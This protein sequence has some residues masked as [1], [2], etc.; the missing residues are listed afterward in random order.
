MN[1]RE[2][3]QFLHAYLDGELDVVN[4]LAVEQH[5][6]E[7]PRCMQQWENQQTLHNQLSDAALYFRAPQSVR[8]RVAGAA[9]PTGQVQRPPRPRILNWLTFGLPLAAV[10][11]VMGLLLPSLFN[12]APARD[13]LMG[14]LTASHIRSLMASHL[15]DVA[16]S[17]QHTVKPWFAGKLDFAP[18]VKDLAAGGF[19]LV[20]GRL[21]YAEQR[22]VAAL[23]YQRNQHVINLFIW[24]SSYTAAS[25]APAGTRQG[26]NLVHWIDRGMSFW[27]VSD[28]NEKELLQ[29]ARRFAQE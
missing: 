24:P 11:A 5:L 13:G 7:C 10:I 14:E 16:S 15:A 22:A 28:L 23:V 29:F 9:R 27:A 26:Y 8:E 20:G 12:R 3:E 4:C 2:T 1:C 17:S 19:P 25:A 6:Q 21:D 18:P